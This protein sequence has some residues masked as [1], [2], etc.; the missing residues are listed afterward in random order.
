MSSN[1]VSSSPTLRTFTLTRN[2][3]PVEPVRNKPSP[4]TL[5]KTLRQC[6]IVQKKKGKLLTSTQPSKSVCASLGNSF[7]GALFDAYSNHHK[8][9]LRPD[10]VWLTVVIALA[11]YIDNHPEEMRKCFVTHDGKKQLVVTTNDGSHNVNN[12]SSIIAHFSNLINENTVGSVRDWIEPKFTTTTENDSLIGRVALMGAMKHYFAYGCCVMCGI[13]EVTL[14]GTLEDWQQLR[15][16]I[17][18]LAE[19][20]KETSQEELIWWRDILIPIADEFIESYKGNVN[21]DFWQSCANHVGGGSGP[22]YVSGWVLAFS[23]FNKGQWRLEHPNDIKLTKRYGQ[24]DTSDFKTSAT[25][26]VPLKINDNGNE[27]DAYFYAGGI[28]NM[29]DDTTNV[30]RPSFDFAMYEMPKGTVPDEIDWTDQSVKTVKKPI[31]SKAAQ[32]AGCPK[33]ITIPDHSHELNIFTYINNHGCDMCGKSG[34]S[35]GYRC[36]SG[37][38]YDCC[39]NCAKANTSS[40]C[41]TL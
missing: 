25:V 38:D 37:C 12:W 1:N 33:T 30:M 29:Y 8:L 14:M 35:V 21:N 16:K 39:L 20:G 32:A 22:S 4:T 10:D 26:E 2:G 13:P 6:N 34:F 40:Y 17:D 19:Y 15:S 11:D 36:G 23:P 28:V 7:I 27:Y 18:R 3:K 24:V 31:I 5:V 9:V 41:I